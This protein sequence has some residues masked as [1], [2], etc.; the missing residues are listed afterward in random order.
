M[1]AEFRPR[2]L[3]EHLSRHGVDFVVIGGVAAALHGS[4]RST[5][6]LDICPAQDADNLEALGVALTEIDARLRG[7]EEDLPFVPDGRSLAGIEILTLSTSLGA[8]DIVI[9]PQGS[10][11][12]AALERR[13]T[14]LSIGPSPV[15]VASM[16]D[17]IAMKRESDRPKDRDDVER[18]ETLAR[19]SRRLAR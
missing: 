17:L 9:R 18:L 19:L 3:L 5:I 8:L 4:D 12:Y 13:A 16:D 10:P 6:D 2:G 7:I 14:R 11:P 15:L 1:P